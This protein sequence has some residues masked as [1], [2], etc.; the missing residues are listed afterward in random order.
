MT[1]K[2]IKPAQIDVNSFLSGTSNYVPKFSTTNSIGNSNISD[3]GSTVTI[4][5]PLTVTGNLSASNISGTNTGDQTN[6]SGNAATAT[7]AL[8][9]D[10]TV[11]GTGTLELV[12]GNMAD[13][14]QFR[15]LVGGSAADSGFVEIATADN[16]T[17]PIYVR[18]YTG[19][20]TNLVRTATL[21]D[22]S[23][24]TSFPGT[25]T[26][27][28]LAAGSTIVDT[29]TASAGLFVTS[30]AVEITGTKTSHTPNRMHFEWNRSGGLG[31][32]SWL[33]QKGA[34]VGGFI[35]G[36]VDTGNT[37]TERLTINSAGTVTI[38]GTLGIGNPVDPA[39]ISIRGAGTTKTYW[40]NGDATGATM[41]ITDTGGSS[42]NGGQILLGWGGNGGGLASAF[43]GIKGFVVNGTGPAG[44]LIFQTRNT[45][46][47]IVERM[48][49]NYAGTVT[50]PGQTVLGTAGVTGGHAGVQLEVHK[51]AGS[52]TS[53]GF[54]QE[55]NASALIGHKSGDANLYITNTYFGNA[56]GTN[57][58][59]VGQKGEV[60]VSG[61]MLFVTPEM[62]GAVGDGVADDTDEINS[63]IAAAIT[64]N[65]EVRLSKSYKVTS[66]ITIAL[67][68][69]QVIKI[70]GDGASVKAAHPAAPL[71]TGSQII[72]EPAIP[73]SF[74]FHIKAATAGGNFANYTLKD[75]AIGITPGYIG[76]GV[77]I[78]DTDYGFASN[79]YSNIECIQLVEVSYIGFQVINTQRINFDNCYAQRRS[80]YILPMLDIQSIAPASTH[81]SFCGDLVIENCNF[82][83]GGDAGSVTMR[84]MSTG[85]GTSDKYAD[86]AGIHFINTVGYFSTYCVDYITSNP[87]SR[88]FDI[89]M[90]SCAFDG[91]TPDM[92]LTLNTIRVYGSG[93]FNNFNFSNLYAVSWKNQA[94]DFNC[95]AGGEMHAIGIN[96]CYFGEIPGTPIAFNSAGKT[97]GI[98]ITANRFKNSGH[99]G[100]LIYIAASGAGAATGISIGD[101]THGWGAGAPMGPNKPGIFVTAGAGTDYISVTGNTGV[102]TTSLS[103]SAAHKVDANNLAIP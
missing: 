15:I 56:L 75:F 90:D 89:F 86:M 23:G 70:I 13:N 51:P 61:H 99:A 59:S 76:G 97:Q 47:D 36:E 49:I 93:V 10:A 80:G 33:N 72:F 6:I 37:V 7:S 8:K 28:T 11:A 81:E 39:A 43:A 74:C 102:W 64:Y 31:E 34:G 25:L 55:G 71:I 67:A 19:I 45:T 66:T 101:N 5:S 29:L 3:N 84:M 91:Y 54:W 44:D 77:K 42:G 79:N 24:N 69:N 40:T 98:N 95:A 1:I 20:F 12:R 85:D 68:S 2:K 52:E 53:I 16:G 78:G 46:G 87:T 50:I 92:N 9:V 38:P 41:F 103:S 100:Q 32:S 63:A 88:I 18:Q 65:C 82:V 4:S 22:G 21:L 17:E 58:I 94:F 27:G 60:S 62:Y 96:N 35:I 30:G 48:R 26:A 57:G 14:D 83:G 73:N